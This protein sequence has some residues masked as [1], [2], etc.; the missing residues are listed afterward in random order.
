MYR[1]APCCSEA[2]SRRSICADAISP[3]SE[4]M[5]N[6]GTS[7]AASVSVARMEAR[8][9]VMHGHPVRHRLEGT[10]P[11]PDGH[12]DEEGEV[13]ER[14]QARGPGQRHAA[15]PGH[16]V[17]EQEEAQAEDRDQQL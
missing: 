7:D 9:L 6:S 12:G 16:E 14:E 1:P 10:H 15:R 13:V 17:A 2:L 4:A 11:A 3:S 8:N 5:A